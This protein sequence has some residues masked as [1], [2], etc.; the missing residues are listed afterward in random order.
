MANSANDTIEEC[1][2]QIRNATYGAQVREAMASGV[3]LCYDD[4]NSAI[5]YN[6][7]QSGIT[8]AQKAI[9]R[10]NLGALGASVVAIAGGNY[11]LVIS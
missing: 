3:E 5:Y 10:A 9:A 4:S 7:A 6:V 8:N 1:V 2:S 11:R